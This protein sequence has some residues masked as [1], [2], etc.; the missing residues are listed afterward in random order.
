MQP[1][2][3][4]T[5]FCSFREL[6]IHTREVICGI[7][8]TWYLSLSP[9]GAHHRHHHQHQ[10][11]RS[12]HKMHF[13]YL[14]N[15]SGCHPLRSNANAC[16]MV[17]IQNNRD[18][19]AS[20]LRI[21][22]SWI[23]KQAYNTYTPSWADGLITNCQLRQNCPEYCWKSAQTWPSIVLACFALLAILLWLLKGFWV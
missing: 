1:E 9:H 18:A 11:R 23:W 4:L 14:W 17:I 8:R 21:G 22:N 7:F 2:N 19:R 12:L 20:V 13:E 10:C 5:Y 16:S 6:W 3:I 15:M